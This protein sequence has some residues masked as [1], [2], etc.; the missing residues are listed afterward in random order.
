MYK[1][2]RVS[3]QVLADLVICIPGFS[4]GYPSMVCQRLPSVLCKFG[5]W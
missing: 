5:V 2:F 4:I 3:P 1:Y